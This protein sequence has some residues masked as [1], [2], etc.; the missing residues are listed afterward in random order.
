MKKEKSKAAAYA[1]KKR[2]IQYVLNEDMSTRPHGASAFTETE[3]MN[4]VAEL[5][6]AGVAVDYYSIFN[7]VKLPTEPE[8]HPQGPL[9]EAEKKRLQRL[10]K[11][12]ILPPS[13][14]VMKEGRTLTFYSLLRKLSTITLCLSFQKS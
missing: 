12:G 2:G 3:V 5:E 8:R 6:A 13:S 11:K 10:R 4:A 9:S 14:S 7:K 1:A